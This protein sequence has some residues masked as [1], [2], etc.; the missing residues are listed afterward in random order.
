[1]A[2]RKPKYPY[3][4]DP[5]SLW[6]PKPSEAL[7]DED[8][9]GFAG[10]LAIGGDLSVNRLIAAYS[11]G[12]FPWYSE[13]TPIFWWSLD[14]RMVMDLDCFRFSKSLRRTVKSGRFEVRVDTCFEQVI[15]SCASVDRTAYG[16]DGT[17]IVEDM[18][19]AYIRLH[20]AGLAHSFETFL[21]GSLVGG[22]YGVSTGMFFSGESMFHT[23]PDASKVAFAKLVEFCRINGFHFIDAQQPT[24]HLASLGAK[25]IPRTIFLERLKEA[26]KVRIQAEKWDYHTVVL[27]FGSNM[28]DRER[29]IREAAV[30]VKERLGGFGSWSSPFYESEPWGFDEPVEG[31]CNCCAVFH[32]K[33]SPHEVL[34]ALHDV[35][36]SLGRERHEVPSSDGKR[37]YES[38][39]IDIDILF[40]DTLQ[41]DAPDLQIPHPRLSQRRFVLE[42][43]A[44]LCPHCE[45]PGT[46]KTVAQLLKDCPD[47][48][49]VKEVLPEC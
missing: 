17:W 39:P 23:V 13:G 36:N 34:E 15:R 28:G 44:R 22:L 10:L 29:T 11:Q 41:L 8:A 26:L 45:C 12:I 14:P 24:P 35:E 49:Q 32:T 33:L 18:I 9:D 20:E 2:R 42:P 4:L 25:P 37:H 6:F 47:H 3:F 27:S 43:L 16:Q 48:S 46:G 30:R 7:T 40:Y 31:F 19:E 21:D 1:M 5:D 38:R